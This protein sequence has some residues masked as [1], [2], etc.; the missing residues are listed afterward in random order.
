MLENSGYTKLRVKMILTTL[1]FSLIPLFILGY[2]IYRQ[3]EISHTSKILQN[4]NHITENKRRT[5]DLFMNERISQLTAIAYTH[6]LSYFLEP[7]T[8]ERVFTLL[9]AR[10]KYY[11]DLGIIDQNGDHVVYTGPY[12]NIRRANYKNEEWF[13]QVQAK[14]IYISDVFLGR[15]NYPHFIIAVMRRDGDKSWVLRA[16]IDSDIFDSL[17]Q[18]NQLGAGGDAFLINSEKVLQSKPRFG[19]KLLGQMDLGDIPRFPGVRSE[20]IEVGGKK[21]LFGLAWLEN[22]NW[23]LAIRD[24]PTEEL[25]PLTHT[26]YWVWGILAGG[27]LLI[28]AG[29]VLTSNTIIGQLVRSEREKASLNASLTQ[30]SKMASLGKMAAGVAHEVNN[31][32]A[33]IKEKAGWMRDLLTEEDVKASPNFKEFEDAITKIEYHVTRAKDVTHRLLG[34]A[35]RLDPIQEDIDI[36]EVLSQTVTFL[37]NEARYRA[38]EINTNFEKSLPFVASDSA[39]LQQVFLNI[40]DNAIDAI[41]KQGSINIRTRAAHD[42]EEVVIT[43]ADTGPGMSKEQLDKIFDPFFTTKKVGEGTGLGL[44]IS[45]SI[46]QKLGGRITVESQEGHGATFIINLPLRK[47]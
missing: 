16:T 43:I 27:L 39:Q 20:M 45:F 8:F 9:Q 32:L 6:K 2:T 4:L 24:D 26:R 28:T 41:G 1:A 22:K 30:S 13:H 44:T 33:I 40:I 7:E 17:V 47:A 31:P 3:F 15:R 38:I 5:L 35:R 36:N 37:E 14:G 12:Q 29:T 25:M 46:I 10:S 42:P 18:S 19:P 11:I 23:L 34:F 21:Y